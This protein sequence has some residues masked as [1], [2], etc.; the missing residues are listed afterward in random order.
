MQGDYSMEKRQ[1]GMTKNKIEKWIKEGRG[2]G[3]GIDYKP[4]L[5]VQDVPSDGRCHREVGMKIPRQY[6]LLSDRENRYF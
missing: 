5:L 3:G 4:W 2:K 1:R 6:T